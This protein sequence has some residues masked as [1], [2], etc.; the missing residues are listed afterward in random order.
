MTAGV[1]KLGV[2]DP[3]IQK[4][5]WGREVVLTLLE[6]ATGKGSEATE[7]GPDPWDPTP[8]LTLGPERVQL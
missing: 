4:E 1:R 2:G 7:L 5:E 3:R 6:L 8:G